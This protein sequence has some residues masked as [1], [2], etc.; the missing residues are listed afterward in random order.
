MAI[1]KNLSEILAL[2]N[3]AY[4]NPKIALNFSNTLELLVAVILSAQCTD[5]MVNIVTSKLFTKYRTLSDYVKADLIEFEKHVKSTGF[6]HNKARNILASAKLISVKYN[7]KVPNNMGDLLTLP[8]VARKTA[9]II[10]GVAYN[11]V[12][13]IAV[14]THVNRI[15][16]RLRLVDLDKIG[17]KKYITFLKAG[18]EITDYKKDADPNKIEKELM[19]NL[20]KSE[21]FNITYRIIEHGRSICK[22]QNPNCKICPLSKLCPSTRI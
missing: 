10:L 12:E 9:N 11:K 17:G 7:G 8:G 14:D 4:P 1:N 13:G 16:Q 15:N 3:K 18:K 22:A 19:E 21:W 2:L 20:D 6:Y 5:K